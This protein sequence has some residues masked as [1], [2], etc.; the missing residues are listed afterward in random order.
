MLAGCTPA[1][2][3]AGPAVQAPVALR[4]A[5]VMADGARLPYAS[6][7][8][9]G[10]PRAII[11]GL[12]G[13]GDYSFNAFDIP[14]P[15]FTAA[16]IGI[17]AYDQR[18]FGA[19]RHSGIWAGGDTLA[20]DA[21]AVTR[22]LRGRYPGIPIVLM[23]ESMGVAVLLVAA[24]GTDPP[25]ADGY[26]LLAP[27][28]R[29]RA[30]M[31]GFARS[32]L[33]FAAHAIPAVG[34]NGSAPGFVPTDNPEAM[35]RWSA[36]PLTLKT[37]R[38]DLLYGL[39]NLMDATLAAAPR[40]DRRA[41]ILYGGKD[42]IV[43]ARPVRLLLRAMPETRARRLAYYPE[44]YHLLLRDRDRA[45]VARDIIAWLAAPDAPLPSGADA[46]AATWLAGPP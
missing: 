25:P 37:F 2:R 46:A 22:L 20:A 21:T 24:T 26:V 30:T 13:F 4:D 19:G 23:G 33:E 43:P 17:F 6:W 8:P 45:A 1:L 9:Q 31:G 7:L 42:V 27:G 15:Q 44:G 35:R 39:V 41:L 36:D 32:S 28:I 18:G 14:A 10:P 11:L 5:F 12:H 3:P 40:F 38:V 34:F 29:G 16:G